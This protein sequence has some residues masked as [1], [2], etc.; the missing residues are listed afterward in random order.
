[1]RNI[2]EKLNLERAEFRRQPVSAKINILRNKAG[3]LLKARSFSLPR[4]ESGWRVQ[5]SGLHAVREDKQKSQQIV[6]ICTP[7]AVKRI[8]DGIATI[9]AFGSIGSNREL[10]L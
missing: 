5:P 3:F 9:R 4:S 7:S 1:M 2:I 8:F 10:T 6:V